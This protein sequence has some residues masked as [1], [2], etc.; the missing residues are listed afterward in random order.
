MIFVL[1]FIAFLSSIVIFRLYAYGQGYAVNEF[2]DNISITVLSECIAIFELAKQFKF[3]IKERYKK[4]IYN[5]SKYTFGIYLVHML[6]LY[7][8]DQYWISVTNLSP[9][10]YIPLSV[11]LVFAIS[12]VI[13]MV[14]NQI[15]VLKKYIV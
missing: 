1:G 15:P 8:L 10:I 14:L 3:N 11:V 12:A 9:G 5:I 13:S 6:I 7:V 4:V 2:Y